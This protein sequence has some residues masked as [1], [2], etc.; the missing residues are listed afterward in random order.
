MRQRL[1][2]EASWAKTSFRDGTDAFV[3]IIGQLH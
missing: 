3:E 2:V 1:S